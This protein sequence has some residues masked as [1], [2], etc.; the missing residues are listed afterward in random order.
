MSIDTGF[1][2]SGFVDDREE[3][4]VFSRLADKLEETP[5]SEVA[6]DSDI[7]GKIDVDDDLKVYDAEYSKDALQ[8][9]KQ[10]LKSKRKE[11]K[12]FFQRNKQQ[13]FDALI[14]LGVIFVAYKLF[15]EK[16]EGMEFEAG[17]DVDYT[18]APQ[19]P[20]APPAPPVQAPPRPEM[21]EPNYNGEQ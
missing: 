16:E 18:P 17:G 13:I 21:P 9:S 7:D 14:V 6:T 12:N 19:N 20:P 15:W 11:G 2:S 3:K 10:S 1:S 5:S 4:E 8:M